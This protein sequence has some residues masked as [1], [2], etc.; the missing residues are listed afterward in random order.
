MK[1]NKVIETS[2]Y[3]DDLDRSQQFYTELFDFDPLVG[4]ARFRALSVN[5]QQVL[6][7]FRKGATVEPVETPL[8]AIPPHDGS[9]EMHLAFAIDEADLESWRELLAGR[10]IAIE[11]T[12]RWPRGGTS[13]YFRDPDRHLL[14]IITPGCWAVY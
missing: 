7:L 14:E 13:L 1:V 6:L 4:D 10:G 8:G 2:L 5:A 3:V 11:C 9:G 12:I